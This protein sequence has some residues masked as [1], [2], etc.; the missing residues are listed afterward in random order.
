VRGRGPE[1]QLTCKSSPQGK[2]RK[3][4][5]QGANAKRLPRG[6]MK[7]NRT[8]TRECVLRPR[9]REARDKAPP[10][11]KGGSRPQRKKKKKTNTS[12]PGQKGKKG[13]GH[14]DSRTSLVSVTRPANVTKRN[15]EKKKRKTQP[16]KK[17]RRGGRPRWLQK[18]EMPSISI[19]RIQ[20]KKK[21]KEK[22]RK[23]E[24]KK[25]GEPGG[26]GTNS[27]LQ[28]WRHHQPTETAEKRKIPS[29]KKGRHTG[30]GGP[31]EGRFACGSHLKQAGALVSCLGTSGHKQ[32]VLKEASNKKRGQ[33]GSNKKKEGRGCR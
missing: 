33:K 20:P 18:Q 16:T 21:K 17:R 6:K 28:N 11:E 29:V 10:R 5:A 3:K 30:W 12:P 24:E 4:E 27:C 13:G 22:L 7:K 9:F 14:G 2:P 1:G 25:G 15:R 19:K 23:I 31:Q 32:R 26:K 8:R